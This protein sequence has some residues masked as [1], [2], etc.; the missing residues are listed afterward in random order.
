MEADGVFEGGGV[1]GI[2]LVGAL[3]RAEEER[4][5]LKRVAGTS[6]GA[7]VASLYAAGYA[8]DELFDLLNKTDFRDF[9]DD[10]MAE[11]KG[12]GFIGW[13]KSLFNKIKVMLFRVSLNY[14]IY[15][16]DIFYKWIKDRLKEKGVTYFKDLKIPLKVVTSDIT[17][18][19]MLIFD[20]EKHADVEVSKAIRMSMSIPIFFY[21]YKWQDPE[22]DMRCL[23]VDGGML[24]NY[25]I[26]IFDDILERP[27]IGFKLISLEETQPPEPITNIVNYIKSILD[28]M[29]LAHEKI[30][31]KDTDWA[32]TIKIPTGDI[33]TTQFDLTDEK[34]DWL[35]RSGYEAATKFFEKQKKEV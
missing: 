10:G 19:R 14:G 6:A 9:M 17:N 34:K 8:A 18:K 28:T 7:I 22:L 21:P 11:K 12:K 30:H 3:K 26:N 2:G 5:V 1:K 32:K 35:Y 23:V 25:P 4:V 31:V 16:G 27:T 15:K 33:K 20:S 24:S 13:L 29:M